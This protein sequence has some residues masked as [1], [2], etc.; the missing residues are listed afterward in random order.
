MKCKLFP[1]E[2]IL[3]PQGCVGPEPQRQKMNGIQEQNKHDSQWVVQRFHD[4][5]GRAGCHIIVLGVI[6][7]A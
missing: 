4:I 3:S 7:L 1:E 5:H 6:V 2:E